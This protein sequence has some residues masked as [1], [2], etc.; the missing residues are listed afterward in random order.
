[1]NEII[2]TNGIPKEITISLTQSSRGLFYVD[3]LSVTG[4]TEDELFS[5]LDKM[6]KEV[7]KRLNELNLNQSS[8]E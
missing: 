5:K 4:N 7:K 6:I 3:K 1:M 2:N 8:D